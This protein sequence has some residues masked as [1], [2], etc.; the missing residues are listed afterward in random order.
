VKIVPNDPNGLEEV[1]KAAGHEYYWETDAV[2]VLQKK[3]FFSFF[4]EPHT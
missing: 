3:I 2:V 4:F 1:E